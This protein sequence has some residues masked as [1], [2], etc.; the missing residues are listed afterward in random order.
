MN[1]FQL[2]SRNELGRKKE[3]IIDY[4]LAIKINSQYD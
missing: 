4:S 1:N 2:N 3:S